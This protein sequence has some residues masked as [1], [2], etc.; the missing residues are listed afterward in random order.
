M[1]YNH[2][3]QQCED[4]FDTAGAKEPNRN[5]FAAFFFRGFCWHQHE[6]MPDGVASSALPK[7]KA[8]LYSWAFV[9]SIWSKAK[10]DS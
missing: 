4:H 3:C 6:R 2:L 8:L 9:D 7:F 5:P 1:E 10:R